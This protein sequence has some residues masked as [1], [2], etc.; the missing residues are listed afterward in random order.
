MSWPNGGTRIEISNVVIDGSR[1]G[2][3]SSYGEVF[4]TGL[5]IQNCL[6]DGMI[7]HKLRGS[8]ITVNDN[9]GAGINMN[10]G[11]M[12]A[13]NVTANGNGFWGIGNG[14]EVQGSNITA[15][16]NGSVGI[17]AYRIEATG[18][19]TKG[20]AMDGVVGYRRALITGLVSTNNG[21]PGLNLP[22]K[23]SRVV[24][25]DSTLSDNDTLGEDIDILS[26]TSPALSNTTCSR[27][28]R[29]ICEPGAWD[30]TRTGES[31]GVCSL[32]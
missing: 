15:N 28:E 5:T 18:M 26:P 23:R 10:G 9:G 20:N 21:G 16:F 14:R 12:S 13:D 17:G 32:D 22:W 29:L 8:D 4:A 19:E 6:W 1:G 31:W 25:I 2:I 24:L 30:C 27:S 3:G 7:V 11:K